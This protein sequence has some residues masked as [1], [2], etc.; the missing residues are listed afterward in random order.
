MKVIISDDGHS[1]KRL[2]SPAGSKL[3][4]I[5]GEQRQRRESVDSAIGYMT[6][7]VSSFNTVSPVLQSQHNRPQL[8]SVSESEEKSL[9][10]P[11]TEEALQKMQAQMSPE[12]GSVSKAIPKRKRKRS[13]DMEVASSPEKARMF[14]EKKRVARNNLVAVEAPFSQTSKILETPA[15]E[16]TTTP[17]LAIIHDTPLA[18]EMPAEKPR[19]RKTS[20]PAPINE[21]I[22]LDSMSESV[23]ATEPA[24]VTSAVKANSK[25][26][27]SQTSAPEPEVPKSPPTENIKPPPMS[28][29]PAIS[30]GQKLIVTTSASPEKSS[31]SNASTAKKSIPATKK[32]DLKKQEIKSKLTAPVARKTKANSPGLISSATSQSSPS[33]AEMIERS[34]K[35]TSPSSTD[36]DSDSESDSSNDDSESDDS[37]SSK[38]QALDEKR[39]K[40][41]LKD[42]DLSSDASADEKDVSRSASVATSRSSSSDSSSDSSSESGSGSESDSGSVSAPGSPISASGSQA[43]SDNSDDESG[44]EA[45]DS[46]S[47][48]SSSASSS[49]SKSS[50]RSR[51]ISPVSNASSDKA[52]S[53]DDSSNSSR[54]V[55]ISLGGQPASTGKSHPVDPIIHRRLLTQE[56]DHSLNSGSLSQQSPLAP[57][58]IR[59][60]SKLQRWGS[61]SDFAKKMREQPKKA[62]PSKRKE[63]EKEQ[64]NESGDE[65]ESSSDSDS[66]SDAEEKHSSGI[67]KDKLAGRAPAAKKRRSG[68]LRSMFK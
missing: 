59:K 53:L 15:K 33:A 42:V 29:E 44:S 65:S 43:V 49:S 14:P 57:F 34:R 40:T 11:L 48:E 2:F 31:T 50:R 56:S 64:D 7:S 46:D 3:A 61:L 30:E 17:E 58:V 36:S 52:S 32:Q 24:T 1:P 39:N 37:A 45:S 60:D 25:G 41:S 47:D 55:A 6:P 38:S 27:K 8:D 12:L 66:D 18:V 68:G 4:L 23:A 13:N 22:E 54:L 67:P 62:I 10:T 9:G 26:K 20:K 63:R 51:S 21:V 16:R 19:A 28:A 5:Q 35:S